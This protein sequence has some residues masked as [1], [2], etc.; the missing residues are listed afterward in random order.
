MKASLALKS[1]AAVYTHSSWRRIV[2]PAPA[3]ISA[4]SRGVSAAVAERLLRTL[5]ATAARSVRSTCRHQCCESLLYGRL[6][7]ICQTRTTSARSST[8][9]RSGKSPAAAAV[10][11][12]TATLPRSAAAYTSV[13]S[14]FV[15]T[16]P[17]APVMTRSAV[18]MLHRRTYA[19]SI[20]ESDP[21]DA[22]MERSVPDDDDDD[23][24]RAC[25]R[26]SEGEGE[27]EIT[28]IGLSFFA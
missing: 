26:A 2:A 3:L 14:W 10:T 17:S 7:A 28:T 5:S 12:V 22:E 1:A 9:G 25:E 24:V 15:V 19:A 8:A 18:A 16:S 13:V 27:R 20:V 21:V 6:E 23:G 4:A 11:A